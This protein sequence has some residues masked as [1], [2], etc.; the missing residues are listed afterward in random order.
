MKLRDLL[1]GDSIQLGRYTATL[2]DRDGVNRGYFIMDQLLDKNY[3]RAGFRSRKDFMTLVELEPDF[4]PILRRLI[5]VR[6]LYKDEVYRVENDVMS[7]FPYFQNPKNIIANHRFLVAWPDKNL[8]M[9][10]EDPTGDAL[11]IDPKDG[12]PHKIDKFQ[13][14]GVRLLFEVEM[15]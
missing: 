11:C 10:F 14:A 7:Q 2:I 1:I 6:M 4:K 5:N 13:L 3:P 15:I 8:L 9:D 12:R